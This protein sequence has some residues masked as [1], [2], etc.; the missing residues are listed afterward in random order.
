METRTVTLFVELTF[1]VAERFFFRGSASCPLGAKIL[2]RACRSRGLTGSGSQG[3]LSTSGSALPLRTFRRC[4]KRWV[5]ALSL[6]AWAAGCARPVEPAGGRGPEETQAPL[7]CTEIEP[8]PAPLRLLTRV[9]YDNTVSDLLGDE[10]RPARNFPVESVVLGFD[11]NAEA[12]RAN[13]L[14]VEAY[15]NAA[16]ELAATAVDARLDALAPCAA[17]DEAGMLTCGRSFIQ[18]FGRRAF[19]RPL[20]ATEGAIY[21]DLFTRSLQLGY[22]RAVRLV[23]EAVLQSPQFLYRVDSLGAPTA[24][25]ETG[26]VL[27]GPYEMA[28]RLA[29]FLYESMPD[30]ELFAAAARNRLATAADVEEQ[31]RRMLGDPRTRL[32]VGD[33]FRQWLELDRLAVAARDPGSL[34]LD[35]AAFAVDLRDSLARF[36]DG[37]FWERGGTVADLFLSPT[38]WVNARLADLYGLARP[39][40]GRAFIAV[41]APDTRAGLLTQPGLMALLAH[42]DQSSPVQRGVFVREHILC[43]HIPD[44]PPTVDNSP[45]DPD[46][47]ATTRERFGVHTQDAVC[48]SCHELI[49]P[50]GFGFEAYDHLGRYRESENGSPID[51]TGEVVGS[52][53]PTLDGP[54]NGARE[55][56][57]RLASSPR[58]ES[59][60]ATHF[61][62][63]AMGRLEEEADKCSLQQVTQAFTASQ[64]DL[65][66]LLVALTLTD[67]FRYR[68]PSGGAP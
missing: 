53:D 10:S 15:M 6:C 28:S 16:V 8:G 24:T 56:A 7:E 51:V 39:A 9:Q 27:V 49:D 32:M 47:N 62:R 23:L 65:R 43:E 25:E 45:P 18:S 12:N 11:N 41:D 20:E 42:A 26:A 44:P 58:V 64:G 2:H 13:P 21:E 57:E 61:Y 46:P 29:Y 66:E 50:V 5:G 22:P 60:L 68:R 33:F 37:V 63:F 35:P 3:R 19:R 40:D 34:A 48:Q 17:T 14:L 55:L 67:A 59:C 38:V 30:E 4:S 31:A 36:V 54:F 1:F 52:A